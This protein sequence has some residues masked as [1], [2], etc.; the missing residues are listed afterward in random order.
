MLMINY[1]LDLV[2]CSVVGAVLIVF[3]VYVVLW[4]KGKEIKMMNPQVPSKNHYEGQNTI[5]V[6]VRSLAEDE[7][8]HNYNDF[9][10]DHEDSTQAGCKLHDIHIEEVN[11]QN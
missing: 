10:K 11:S 6:I 7:S 2:K 1:N 4:G 5:Q 9:K 8:N 3:G